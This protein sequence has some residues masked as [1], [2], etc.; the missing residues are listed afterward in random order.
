[1]GEWAGCV[2]PMAGCREGA[3]T[4]GWAEQLP[5]GG[6]GRWPQGLDFPSSL[7]SCSS[8]HRDAVVLPNYSFNKSTAGK[9]LEGKGVGQQQ[10]SVLDP[11][12]PPPERHVTR[13][14][15]IYKYVYLAAISSSFQWWDPWGRQ[16]C[17]HYLLS[18]G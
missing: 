3:A 6:H 1:M 2:L 10:G 12:L 7:L 5:L 11:T 18:T 15:I 13:T 9:L 17:K 16:E 14:L 4:K 8:G